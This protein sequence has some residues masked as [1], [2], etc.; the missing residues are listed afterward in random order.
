MLFLIDAGLGLLTKISPALNAFSLG[1]PAKIL[2]T[3]LMVGAALP[4]L[5][6]TVEPPGRPRAARH[7]RR[8][9]G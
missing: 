4:L 9:G 1:F 6:E 5:P 7:E 8:S 3:L 2:V